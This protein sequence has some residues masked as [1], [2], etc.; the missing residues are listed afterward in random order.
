MDFDADDVAH[1]AIDPPDVPSEQAKFYA[2]LLD[3]P[4]V[5]FLM[6]NPLLVLLLLHLAWKLVRG[7]QPWPTIEYGDVTSV[8]NMD[9]WAAVLNEGA[10]TS[11][12]LVVDCYALWCP[13]CKAAAPAY[14]RMSEEFPH[15]IFAKVDVDQARD[16]A[17][18]LGISA[19]PTFKAFKARLE[20]GEV[21]GWQEARVRELINKNASKPAAGD[22]AAF[23]DA[24]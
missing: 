4:L 17:R 22:D 9:A 18:E 10:A 16:V 11:K 19:M 24:D 7:R 2:P 8:P 20:V 1:T 14:A 15:V 6:R 23:V 3:N 13:P 5:A 12:L 21:R